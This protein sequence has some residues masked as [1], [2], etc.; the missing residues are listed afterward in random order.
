MTP[1]WSA[2]SCDSVVH[3]LLSMK[4]ELAL[5]RFSTLGRGAHTE[6]ELIV[7]ELS[8]LLKAG[9]TIPESVALLHDK[10]S[11]P[12]SSKCLDGYS[13]GLQEGDPLSAA[14]AKEGDRFPSLLVAMTRASEDAASL[15]AG[16]HRYLRYSMLSQTL[17]RKV[18]AA[19]IYPALLIAV[20]V[21]VTIFL[22]VFVVPRF[23][24]VFEDGTKSVPAVTALLLAASRFS[25]SIRSGP[26]VGGCDRCR[27]LDR[28]LAARGGQAANEVDR[29]G[30]RRRPAPSHRPCFAHADGHVSASGGWSPAHAGTRSCQTGA[31]SQLA[32][33]ARR[34]AS[35]GGTGVPL[36]KF[37]FARRRQHL[38]RGPST[39]GSGNAQAIWP[40]WQHKLHDIMKKNSNGSSTGS[41]A[42]P[43]LCL[44]RSSDW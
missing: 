27:F 25:F 10:G 37:A 24:A 16:L 11:H 20:A 13:V 1:Q 34:D 31:A 6:I 21:A 22:A 19:V 35:F 7:R 33:T 39:A 18:V 8:S 3:R 2:K 9:L 38:G 28:R 4:R 43:S 36:V 44:W 15:G 17:R 5:P 12:Y 29:I 40:E 26:G 30:T 23:A 14:L 32:R 41:C 42:L